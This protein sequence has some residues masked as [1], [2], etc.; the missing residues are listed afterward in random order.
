GLK[1][2]R[3]K[4][5]VMGCREDV[6]VEGTRLQKVTRIKY[7][8]VDISVTGS[9]RPDP[10]L[11]DQLLT[12]LKQARLKPLQKLY[13][14]RSHLIPTYLHLLIHEDFIGSSLETMDQKIRSAAKSILWQL[15]S[16][17]NACVHLKV[18]NGGMGIPQLRWF[19]PNLAFK[20]MRRLTS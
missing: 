3:T 12:K 8:G 6:F 16:M 11:F 20:R 18:K 17:P 14:L 15:S 9:I 10:N 2:N 1:L 7:L 13:F 4:S 5:V 19:I